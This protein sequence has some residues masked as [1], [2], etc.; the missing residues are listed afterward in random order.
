[1]KCGIRGCPGHYER[2]R[3]IHT[4]KRGSEILVFENIPAEVC[5][6]CYD[7]LLA[8]ETIRYL[9]GLMRQDREPDRYVP[10]YEYG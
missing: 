7:V 9:E 2:Q 5:D 3:I 1:M 8:P 10:V 6:V 4:V